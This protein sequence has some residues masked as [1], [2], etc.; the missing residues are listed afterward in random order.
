MGSILMYELLAEER[1][2]QY[3]REAERDRQVAQLTARRR[4][5]RV[6]AAA[7]PAPQRSL[8]S[9]STGTSAPAA[10]GRTAA[11]N[12]AGTRRAL[13]AAFVGLAAIGALGRRRIIGR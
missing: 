13:A 10:P 8:T 1:S 2:A 3:R 5:G 6:D 9:A 7:A 4:G 11:A 12:P